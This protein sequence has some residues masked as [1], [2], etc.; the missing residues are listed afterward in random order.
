MIKLK[1]F[2]ILVLEG[3][4]YRP[5]QLPVMWRSMTK[6]SHCVIASQLDPTMVI[7]PNIGGIRY[8][9][10]SAFK[11]RKAVVCRYKGELDVAKLGYWL[12][13]TVCNARG[14]D[15]LAWLGFITCLKEF[16]CQNAWFCSELAYWLFQSNNIKLTRED[17]TF[18][19]PNFFVEHNDFV[20]VYEGKL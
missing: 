17:L 4:W 1:S 8:R 6:Y 9:S 14:Y 10:L 2:D 16:E 19:F 13:R 11:G 3:Q 7:D 15:Y 18:M 5:E 12:Q 20:T